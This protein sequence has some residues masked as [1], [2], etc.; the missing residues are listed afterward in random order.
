MVHHRK[1]SPF[2]WKVAR[3]LYIMWSKHLQILKLLHPTIKVEMYIYKKIYY[4]T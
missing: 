3:A 4:L 2:T 1:W